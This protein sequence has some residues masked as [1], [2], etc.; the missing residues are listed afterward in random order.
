VPFG[1]PLGVAEI[2]VGD[3]NGDGRPD[4][5]VPDFSSNTVGVL[6][7]SGSWNPQA[8]TTTAP[9]SPSSPIASAL[10]LTPSVS[11]PPQSGNGTRAVLSGAD[12][13]AVD[14]LFGSLNAP[15]RMALVFAAQSPDEDGWWDPARSDLF[16]DPFKT[17]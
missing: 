14:L 17:P 8:S 3:F 2:A 6:I 10:A 12:I 13:S 7:N 15:S 4:V 5:A 1:L 9:P 11:A 16:L